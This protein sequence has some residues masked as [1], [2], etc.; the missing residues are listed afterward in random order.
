MRAAATALP[1]D[2]LMV[3]TGAA[4]LADAVELTRAAGDLGFSA[5]LV[6][7]P[8]YYKD[9]TSEGLLSFFKR[10]C[11]SSDIG[12]YLYN[13]PQLTGLRFEPDLVESLVRAC[14]D[15]IIGMKDSSGDLAYA[16]TIVD[17]GLGLSVFPSSEA[18]LI[19]ARAGNFA[20][21]I[22]ATASLSAD[23]CAEAWR[24][25][26][27]DAHSRACAMRSIA[28]QGPLIPRI[29]AAL[30]A[31]LH[32]PELANVLPPHEPLTPQDRDLLVSQ[33]RHARTD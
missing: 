12:V 21:C 32:D 31:E 29:K 13:F 27:A 2:R 4:A 24:H 26:K 5:A 33:L 30:A 23:P 28:A 7:P 22:S 10:V 1:T 18:T 11:A 25:G 3:G 14:P 17:L 6:L 8:F 20:G 9:V 19:Q 16:R 15:R